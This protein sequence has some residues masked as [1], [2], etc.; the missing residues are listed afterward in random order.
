MAVVEAFVICL[1][2]KLL[3]WDDKQVLTVFVIYY[4]FT[5]ILAYF[6]GI[7][8]EEFKDEVPTWVKNVFIRRLLLFVGAIIIYEGMNF[9]LI[10][11]VFGLAF[12]L[13]GA[14]YL[15]KK[16]LKGILAKSQTLFS[17]RRQGHA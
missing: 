9:G 13:R 4:S 6:L 7:G 11:A 5:C 3:G 15:E 2:F 12:W 17:K 16:F 1:I 14:W 8:Y 10:P